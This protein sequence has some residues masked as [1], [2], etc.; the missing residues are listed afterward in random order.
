MLVKYCPMPSSGIDFD[1]G[2]SLFAFAHTFL[3][4]TYY[5][6]TGAYCIATPPLL[7]NVVWW[8]KWGCDV[9]A[10]SANVFAPSYHS[11]YVWRS[12]P[13]LI[14]CYEIRRYTGIT[15]FLWR[16]II[17]ER[18][19]IP[20]ITRRCALS[21]VHIG[22]EWDACVHLAIE[23]NGRSRRMIDLFDVNIA[24]YSFYT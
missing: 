18:F 7:V 15:V 21:N 14:R 6:V 23:T 4:V 24:T 11:C 12:F 2:H 1:T 8:H 9:P 16:Y 17:V 20:R 10:C 19:L 13:Q 3:Q 22:T 5:S